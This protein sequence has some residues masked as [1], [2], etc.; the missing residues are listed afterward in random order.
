MRETRPALMNGN[1]VGRFS[2][3]TCTWPPTRSF[4]AGAVPLYGT[5]SKSIPACCLNSSVS[6]C[7]APPMPEIATDIGFGDDFASAISSATFFAGTDGCTVN[8][9]GT[10]DMITTP[11]RSFVGT[12][13]RFG[14]SAGAVVIGPKLPISSV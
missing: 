9:F 7:V 14:V 13:D 6:R 2:K 12:Y 11:T 3:S 10:C 4:S 5:L 1:I 8:T